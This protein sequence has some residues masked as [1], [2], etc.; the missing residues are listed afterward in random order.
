MEETMKFR[1]A[2][3]VNI[4]ISNSRKGSTYEIAPELMIHLFVT[5]GYAEQTENLWEVWAKK[6]PK[7]NSSWRKVYVEEEEV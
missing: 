3:G 6:K 1:E 7:N 2:T 5:S 4:S